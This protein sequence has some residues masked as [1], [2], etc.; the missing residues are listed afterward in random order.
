MLSEVTLPT[1][2]A[3]TVTVRRHQPR[4][5]TTADQ[6]LAKLHSNEFGSIKFSE[7]SANGRQD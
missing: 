2:D 4:L 6:S 5:T 1:K 7:I 3:P